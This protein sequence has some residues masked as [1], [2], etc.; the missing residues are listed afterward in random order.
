MDR[1]FGRLRLGRLI[2]VENEIEN[3][4]EIEVEV[5]IEIEGKRNVRTPSARR[6]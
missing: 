6:R 2:K 1:S 4:N 5:E 3:K